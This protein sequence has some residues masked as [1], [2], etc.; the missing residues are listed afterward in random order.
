[1]MPGRVP[2]KSEG[3]MTHL[4]SRA[5]STLRHPTMQSTL[6]HTHTHMSKVTRKH[7]QMQIADLTTARKCHH[8]MVRRWP[9]TLHVQLPMMME[10]MRPLPRC[11]HTHVRSRPLNPAMR[12]LPLTE[13]F[14]LRP[15][16][17]TPRMAHPRLLDRNL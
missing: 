6:G 17:R 15:P 3:T 4:R 7:R 2:L 10:L 14:Q 11:H 16:S 9:L 13:M 12:P 5:P 8:E 1:V